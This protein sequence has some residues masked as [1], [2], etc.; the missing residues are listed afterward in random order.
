MA[1]SNGGIN[2]D[3][4][5]EISTFMVEAGFHTISVAQHERAESFYGGRGRMTEIPSAGPGLTISR[6]H[7]PN[8]ALARHYA[9]RA[10]YIRN[11]VNIFVE[12]W[13]SARV[14][15]QY[16]ELTPRART[17]GNSG[18]T[19]TSQSWPQTSAVV[20]LARGRGGAR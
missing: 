12:A 17:N 6:I 13:V 14:G 8:N 7:V 20:P 4:S 16:D 2:V 3:A 18:V 5:N 10:Q 9:S 1:T 11:G 15:L 19:A